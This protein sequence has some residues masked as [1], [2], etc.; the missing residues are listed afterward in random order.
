MTTQLARGESAEAWLDRYFTLRCDI[1]LASRA[2]QRQGIDRLFTH[3]ITGLTYTVEYK[4]DW[5]A[6]R[7]GNAF[8]ETVSVDT[9]KIAGWA[10]TSQA[11]WLVYFIPGRA[12]IYLIA[13]AAL[14]AQLPRWLVTC[15][16]APP[17]PNRSYHT[18]GIL[19]P[20]SQLAQVASAVES[21]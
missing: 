4:T 20:L 8:I 19:V 15:P 3:R 17:I 13:F 7:T 5:T 11:E 16:A 21:A 18:L 14:R 10:Y 1:Q 9:E 6:A 2:Q 12:T